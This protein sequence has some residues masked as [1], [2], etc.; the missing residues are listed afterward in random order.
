[1]FSYLARLVLFALCIVAHA[2]ALDASV[3]KPGDPTPQQKA[4]QQ[5]QQI[6]GEEGGFRV[7]IEKYDTII[8]LALTAALVGFT[9]VLAFSTWSLW[10][11]TNR[12]AKAANRSAR[13][14]YDSAKAAE[15]Q[16]RVSADLV[17]AAEIDIFVGKRAY[18]FV[19]PNKIQKIEGG[20]ILLRLEIANEGDTPAI[21][22][23]IYTQFRDAAPTGE[24]SVH[25]MT[26][27]TI[28]SV[29]SA[30]KEFTSPDKYIHQGAGECYFVGRI[31]Y[32]DIFG[33][34]HKT[35]FCALIKP[36]IPQ[37]ISAGPAEWNAWD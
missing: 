16:A 10:C 15:D 26:H 4:T 23:S 9:G 21:L 25:G 5:E 33:K 1:M 22:R 12:V 35:W 17:R 8:D 31:D 32:D 20:R 19:G 7:W 11:A 14:A 27:K 6:D 24:P 3:R 34:P 13:A 37:F 18:V 28:E 36:D 29:L 30:H 2:S